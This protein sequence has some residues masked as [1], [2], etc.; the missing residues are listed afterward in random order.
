MS[1]LLGSGLD[2]R[3][4]ALCTALIEERGANPEALAAVL[5]EL[6]SVSAAAATLKR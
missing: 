6:A 1:D 3:T 2:G 5:K 4:L